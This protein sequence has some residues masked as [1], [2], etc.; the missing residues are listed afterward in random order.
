MSIKNLNPVRLINY[1]SLY[2]LILSGY[3]WC[4]EAIKSSV[5]APLAGD[6]EIN[7]AVTFL[8]QKDIPQAL[9]TLKSF[10][11]KESKVASSAATNMAFIHLLVII[12]KPILVI[13]KHSLLIVDIGSSRLL[14]ERERERESVSTL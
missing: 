6:L 5:Y 11:R 2:T 4:V 9:D 12:L 13:K 8:K 1:V 10:Q 3:N 7:K 14:R